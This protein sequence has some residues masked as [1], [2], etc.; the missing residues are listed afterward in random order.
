MTAH[1]LICEENGHIN[2]S[3]TILSS[4]V[5]FLSLVVL[6]FLVSLSSTGPEDVNIGYTAGVGIFFGILGLFAGWLWVLEIDIADSIFPRAVLGPYLFPLGFAASALVPLMN[7]VTSDVPPEEVFFVSITNGL[8]NGVFFLLVGLLIDKYRLIRNDRQR[9]NAQMQTFN[10]PFI[11]IERLGI[12]KD[13]GLLT[14]EEFES[15]KNDILKS[16]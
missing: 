3:M 7:G 1:A 14:D 6:T 12:L 9:V 13:R 2:K 11:L 5:I 15:K 4:G 16:I 10:D 8:I